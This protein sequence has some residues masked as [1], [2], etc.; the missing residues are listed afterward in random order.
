MSQDQERPTNRNLLA[1]GLM[2]VAA[3]FALGVVIWFIMAGGGDDDANLGVIDDHR[4]D[5]GEIAP[6]FALLD[7]RDGETVR[8]LS[9]YRGQAVVLNW[10]ASWCNPCKEEIPEFQEAQDALEG[11]VVF[12]LVNLEQDR[13]EANRFLDELDAT[14]TSVLDSDGSV[15]RHYRAIN[16]P[17]TYFIDAE[18]RISSDG[19][20][21]VSEEI[22][23]EELG[24]L[25]LEY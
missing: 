3:A 13:G 9:D 17:T 14:M 22:L 24:K 21:F 19:V 23:R 6:D 5:T 8:Q 2:S 16:L 20:G 4:P 11:D 15:A 10:Y 18:G 7:V 12:L 25:G 1:I